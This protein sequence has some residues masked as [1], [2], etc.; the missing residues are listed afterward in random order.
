MIYSGKLFF[1][2]QDFFFLFNDH[3]QFYCFTF[4]SKTFFFLF[5][6]LALILLLGVWFQFRGVA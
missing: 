2:V 3:F 5:K 1:S 4:S 6:C